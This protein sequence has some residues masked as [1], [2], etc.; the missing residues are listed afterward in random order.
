MTTK[1]RATVVTR[2]TS[3]TPLVA[4]V[5]ALIVSARQNVSI[6]VN[7]SLIWLHW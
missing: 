7:A 6:A 4:E 5:R 1:R 3:D 2:R